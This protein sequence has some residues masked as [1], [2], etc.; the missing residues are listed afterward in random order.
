MELV[1]AAQE[2]SSPWENQD[3]RH[4]GELHGRGHFSA[5]GIVRRKPS[6]PDA[7]P[8]L[9][10]SCTD[11]IALTQTLSFLSSIPSLVLGYAGA[12]LSTLTIPQSQYSAKGCHRAFSTV[13]RLSCL[14]SM[15]PIELFG[16]KFHPLGIKT[17]TI[18]FEFSRRVMGDRKIVAS[19]IA[20]VWSSSFEETLIG[21]ILQGRKIGDPRGASQIS[22]RQMAML[23][24]QVVNVI[25]SMPID[26]TECFRKLIN[27]HNYSSLKHTDL[28]AARRNAKKKIIHVALQ[29]WIKNVEDNFIL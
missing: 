13:G 14:G 18:E 27:S 17:T 23:L 16:Y 29:G 11:K 22:R 20:S 5:L 7:T 21:G 3:A 2:D 4:F 19:N 8:T 12:Y 28:L 10:K 15:Q 26:G 24:L 1:M 25:I 6:R 9:S